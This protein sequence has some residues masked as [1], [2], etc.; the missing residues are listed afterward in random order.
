MNKPIG[1][2]FNNLKIGIGEVSKISGVS[3]RQLRYWEQKGYI[4]P[5]D[6]N[7]GVRV[8]DF[9]SIYTVFYIKSK[10]DEGYTLSTAYEKSK[11]TYAKSQ[12]MR[13]FFHNLITGVELT[14]EE[15]G[16][17]TIDFNDDLHINNTEYHLVGVVDENGNHFEIKKKN[18]Y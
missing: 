10:L 1:K 16:Y 3:Q 9:A 15:K 11:S 12:V 14:D 18:Q 6:T 8:Y 5:V 2:L 7:S 17:G 13:K 4:K